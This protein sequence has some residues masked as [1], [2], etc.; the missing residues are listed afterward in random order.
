MLNMASRDWRVLSDAELSLLTTAGALV[1]LA[2]ER[3]RLEAAS[4]RAFAAEERNRLARE[5]HD[6]L[7]QGLAA[8][9]M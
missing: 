1:S 4:A 7:A 6:T 5:I 8:L 9:T 3:S 2:V